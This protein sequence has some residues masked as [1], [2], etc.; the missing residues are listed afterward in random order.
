MK[1]EVFDIFFAIFVVG[2]GAGWVFSA[3]LYKIK[4][5][6]AKLKDA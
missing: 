6:L 1:E 2:F 3:A 4:E 5:L